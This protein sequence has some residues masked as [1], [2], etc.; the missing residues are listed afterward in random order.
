MPKP[1]ILEV[2]GMHCGGCVK[3]VTKALEALTGVKLGRVDIGRV[4]GEIEEGA[5]VDL[6]ALQAAIK[7]AGYAAKAIAG[8]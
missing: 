6:A 3:R 4:V 1:F 7:R 5:A 2:D 8:G